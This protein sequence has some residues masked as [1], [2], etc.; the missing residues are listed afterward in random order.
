MADQR[1]LQCTALL[2]D[3]VALCTGG[4]GA[5]YGQSTNSVICT[6]SAASRA[7]QQGAWYANAEF[8]Q[9]HP[10]AIPGKDKCRLISE[11]VRGEGGRVWVPKDN[12]DKRA[13]KDIPEGERWY[14]LEEKY[15]RHGN[16]GQR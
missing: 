15:P 6:A 9:I 12:A 7:Y 5:I 8:I 14:F 10:T 4:V 16:L 13:G 11:S 3:A 2:G 1:T